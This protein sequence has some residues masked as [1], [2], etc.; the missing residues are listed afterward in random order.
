MLSSAATRTVS[1]LTLAIGASTAISAWAKEPIPCQ[2]EVWE[3]TIAAFEAAD[4]KEPPPKQGVLFVGSSSIRMWDLKKSFPDLAVINRGFGGS[5]ICHATHFV[6]RLIAPHNPRVVVF[7]AG[8]NDIAAGKSP[9]QVHDD[10]RAFV[11]AVRKSLPKTPIVFIAIKPSI[12]RWKLAEEIKAA[13]K[14]IAADC[15]KDETLEFVN[16]WPGMLGEDG[17]PRAE[18]LRDDK[19][20]MTP[21]GYAVWTELLLPHLEQ[22]ASK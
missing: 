11:A 5:Q 16:V 10:F 1:L 17:M 14:L 9:E 4:A 22:K 15:V 18:L 13:N 7:Y 20:H 2:P 6:D 19:L 12:A 8:D 3:E 21:A